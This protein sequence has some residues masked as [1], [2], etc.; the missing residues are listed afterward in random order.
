VNNRFAVTAAMA[1][2]VPAAGIVVDDFLVFFLCFLSISISL[3]L[4]DGRAVG[5]RFH[6]CHVSTLL[7]FFPLQ[8]G[9]VEMFEL[10]ISLLLA[11]SLHPFLDAEMGCHVDCLVASAV[12]CS[13]TRRH[14]G[15][16]QGGKTKESTS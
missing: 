15:G 5:A 4:P 14:D 12:V 10:G 16:G 3:C 6:F 7:F 1:T 2:V 8:C 9:A 13:L 11:R